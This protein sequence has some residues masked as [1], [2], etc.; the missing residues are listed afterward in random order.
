[1][2]KLILVYYVDVREKAPRNIPEYLRE[3]Y[4]ALASDNYT[5]MVIPTKT[6]E[7]RV[8]CINPVVLEGTEAELHLEK[9]KEC[10]DDYENYLKDIRLLEDL[11]K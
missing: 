3:A 1:M 10:V 7:S 11:T 5:T 9:L 2:N 8:E 6:G 4:K